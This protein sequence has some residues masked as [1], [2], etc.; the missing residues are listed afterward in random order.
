MNIDQL[1]YLYKICS[2]GVVSFCT[3][4][5]QSQNFSYDDGG[6]KREEWG[7]VHFHL[8]YVGLG[9]ACKICADEIDEESKRITKLKNIFRGIQGECDD[10]FINGSER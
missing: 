5:T 1:V 9:E 8:R 6:R 3:L 7:Q 4:K 2:K 10:I